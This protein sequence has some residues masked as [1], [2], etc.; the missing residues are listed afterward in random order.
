M[1]YH[2]LIDLLGIK[3]K[4]AEVWEV[5]EESTKLLVELYTRLKSKHVHPVR[6]KQSECIATESSWRPIVHTWATN[7]QLEVNQ[8]PN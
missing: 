4:R 8:Y 2:L 5:K 3:V 7:K 6:R 1:Q